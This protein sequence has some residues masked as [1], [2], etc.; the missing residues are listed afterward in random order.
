MGSARD[1]LSDDLVE[2][3]QMAFDMFDQKGEGEISVQ[4][5]GTI[6]KQIGLN[7]SRKELEEIMAEADEDGSGTMDFDEFLEL[8]AKQMH[9][10]QYT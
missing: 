7:P 5:L 8:M 6:L 10:D 1:M 4:N 9:Q 3:F 2:E